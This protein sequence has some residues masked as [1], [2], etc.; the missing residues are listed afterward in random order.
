MQTQKQINTMNDNIL[1]LI[2]FDV[3]FALLKLED[4]VKKKQLKTLL[5]RS[6]RILFDANEL[7]KYLSEVAIQKYFCFKRYCR[8]IN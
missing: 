4:Q 1:S 3:C 8:K 6:N 2:H 7:T 5:I